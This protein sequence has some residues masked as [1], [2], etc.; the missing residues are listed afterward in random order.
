M[1]YSSIIFTVVVVLLWLNVVDGFIPTASCRRKLSALKD[2][3]NFKIPKG[4]VPN[5]VNIDGEEYMSLT[6]F[7]HHPTVAIRH[8]KV[9]AY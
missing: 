7:S 1:G 2:A 6:P 8:V 3:N 5:T 9:S 4:Y